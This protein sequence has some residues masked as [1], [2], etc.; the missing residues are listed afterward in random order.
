MK[1]SDLWFRDPEQPSG[2]TTATAK[3]IGPAERELALAAAGNAGRN[4]EGPKAGRESNTASMRLITP[5]W[6][7]RT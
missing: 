7:R 1:R 5:S 6:K 4:R 3:W 2:L